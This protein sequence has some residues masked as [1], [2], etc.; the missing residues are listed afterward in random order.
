[1][2]KQLNYDNFNVMAIYRLPPKFGETIK[3]S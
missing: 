1:M 2:T 3:S